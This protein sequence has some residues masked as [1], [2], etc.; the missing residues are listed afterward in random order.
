MKRIARKPSIQRLVAVPAALLVLLVTFH[1][2]AAQPV[3]EGANPPAKFSMHRTP[4]KLPTLAFNDSAGHAVHLRDFHGKVVVLNVWATWC[5]PCRK[6]MP[7]LDRLQAKLGGSRFQVVALSADTT[8][9]KTVQA[10]YQLIGIRHLAAYVDPTS[11]VLSELDVLAL[12]T[13]L[14]LDRN[15]AEIG[16][17]TGP[18]EWDNPE[19]IAFLRDVIGGHRNDRTVFV[20]PLRRVACVHVAP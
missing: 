12:P 18:A 9:P 10:F 5:A 15:G 14:L 3:A 2:A 8:G 6:E 16:R 13:T 17:L 7:T 19:M 1:D 11:Q 20:P 4:R